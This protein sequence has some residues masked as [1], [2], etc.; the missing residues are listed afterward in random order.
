[1]ALI[2]V[3][4]LRGGVGT[5]FLAANIA[6]AFAQAGREATALDFA[7]HGTLPLH[8]GLPLDHPIAQIDGNPLEDSAPLGVTLRAAAQFAAKGD[9]AAALASGE[10]RFSGEQVVVADLATADEA[11]RAMLLPYA[12]L[13]IRVLSATAESLSVLPHVLD[14]ASDRTFYLINMADDTRRFCRHM[15]GFLRELLGDRLLGSIRRDEA[16]IEAG[17]MLQPLAKYA[18]SSASLKDVQTLVH[19]LVPRLSA[20]F[21]TNDETAV[22]VK[23][24]EDRSR[25]TTGRQGVSRAA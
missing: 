4:G 7:A 14:E 13:D 8:F 10:I 21:A 18:P 16:V 12:A 20:A 19:D 17:A 15:A 24:A 5:T 3:Q 1:M 22:A 11:T 23:P 6:I 9:L 25:K 2:V